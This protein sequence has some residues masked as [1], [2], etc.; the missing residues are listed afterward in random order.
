MSPDLKSDITLETSEYELEE[1]QAYM[2]ELLAQYKATYADYEV[3]LAKVK[4]T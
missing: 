2:E 1:E 4:H 3:K